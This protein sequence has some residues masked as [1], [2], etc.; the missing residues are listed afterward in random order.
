MMLKHIFDYIAISLMSKRAGPAR[1]SSLFLLSVSLSCS[2]PD[3]DQSFVPPAARLIGEQYGIEVVWRGQTRPTRTYHGLI[4]ATDARPSELDE[5]SPLLASE[6]LLYPPPLIRRSGRERII[7]CR[8]LSFNGQKRSAVPD[9]EHDAL[10]LDV[11]QG[12]YSGPYRRR[13]IHHEF[14][15]LIDFRDD[16]HLYSDEQWMRLNR[17][18]FR[19]G[20]GGVR[21]QDDP[22]T[23]LRAS[24]PGFLTAYSMSGVE[25]DKAE[26]FAHMMTEYTAVEERAIKDSV[27]REK[28]SRMKTLME[29]FCPDI[30]AT[31]W[32]RVRFP[33]P[34]TSWK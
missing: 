9:F 18:T 25:E 15:H 8:D 16:G 1:M 26:V 23:G 33:R 12:G 24:I 20:D 10:Y 29:R 22:T 17:E 7:L 6:F 3:Y 30:D 21:M 31:F 14:F 19:Y 11:V 32:R 27:I 28:M 34:G 13:V 4:R 2:R 5:Y